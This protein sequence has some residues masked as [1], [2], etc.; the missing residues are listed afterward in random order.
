MSH[1]PNVTEQELI[2]LGKIAEQQK[3][4]RAIDIK[5]RKKIL[6]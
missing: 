2:N 5:I 3:N 1:Y 4:Q 6:K